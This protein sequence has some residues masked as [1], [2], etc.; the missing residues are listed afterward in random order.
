MRGILKLEVLTIIQRI[1]GDVFQQNNARAH[2]ALNIQA[3]FGAR[4]VWF[5]LWSVCFLDM[6]TI[7]MSGMTWDRD[8][9][10][11]KVRE[12]YTSSGIEY[13]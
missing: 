2:V 3:F 1:P 10:V 9:L 12:S 8:F 7:D 13:D 6:L 4:K 11:P 5:R